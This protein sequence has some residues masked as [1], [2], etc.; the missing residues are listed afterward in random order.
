MSGVKSFINQFE[1]L[2][3]DMG[4]TFMF[5]GDR[6]G[7]NIDYEKTYREMGGVKLQ[8]K[9]LHEITSHIYGTLLNFSRTPEYVDNMITV[10]EFISRDRFFNSYD[11][12]EKKNI[13]LVFTIHECGNIPSG[14]KETLLV[15]SKHFHLG[16][17]SN[18]WSDSKHF[19]E[20]LKLNN[21]YYLFEQ[22]IFSSD[23]GSAKPSKKLF[24]I[25]TK[26][27]NKSPEEIVY[28]GDNYK[29]DVLGS[30]NAGMKSILVQNSISGKITGEIQPDYI[31]HEIEELV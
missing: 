19:I 23:F 31:I 26:H 27:F 5:D 13:E 20:F 2:I 3:F 22:I 15:L 14:C 21:V 8:N 10:R 24:D 12:I 17:I 18:I 6:F 29:R 28:I 7:E 1:V 9:E 30:K 16:I 25:A 11:A 4:R